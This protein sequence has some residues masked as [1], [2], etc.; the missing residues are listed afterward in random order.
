MHGAIKATV[1]LRLWKLGMGG[2]IL[3]YIDSFDF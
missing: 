1:S 3:S 2:S